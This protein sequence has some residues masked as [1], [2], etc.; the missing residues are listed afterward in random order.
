M[1]ARM[2]TRCGCTREIEVSYPPPPEFN[3]PLK[4]I[5]SGPRSWMNTGIQ[6]YSPKEHGLAHRRFKLSL[7]S[8]NDYISSW[9]DKSKDEVWYDEVITINDK[10]EVI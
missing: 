4:P 8:M 9:F 3:L 7:E 5:G 1:K 6:K 2:I 10:G